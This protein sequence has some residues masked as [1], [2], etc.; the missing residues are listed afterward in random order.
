MN[1]Q[2]RSYILPPADMK[3]ADHTCYIPRKP[4]HTW[5]GHT[6]GVQVIRFFPRFGHFLLSGSLDTKVSYNN[7]I[8]SFN[9]INNF[10]NI[11]NRLNYGMLTMI[12]NV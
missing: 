8:N 5:S 2:G 6:K 11:I 10:I 12:E 4:I 1:Y 7:Y 9:F 3:P